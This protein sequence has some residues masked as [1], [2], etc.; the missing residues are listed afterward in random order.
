MTCPK[1]HGFLFRE[2]DPY[3]YTEL[4]CICCGNRFSER[5]GI[6][7]TDDPHYRNHVREGG[8]KKRSSPVMTTRSIETQERTHQAR[9]AQ[10]R[11]RQQRRHHAVAEA[12]KWQ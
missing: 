5:P 7:I 11:I 12:P 1:C 4:S 9:L 2:R 6:P 3:G 10:E 8:I